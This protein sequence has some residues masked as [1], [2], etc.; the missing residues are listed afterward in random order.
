MGAALGRVAAGLEGF[1]SGSA[2]GELDAGLAF[3]AEDMTLVTRC[4]R[5]P[6]PANPGGYV[7]RPDGS[8]MRMLPVGGIPFSGPPG[9]HPQ[10]AAFSADIYCAPRWMGK[11]LYEVHD[12][13]RVLKGPPHP[14]Y[15]KKTL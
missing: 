14:T 9:S 10:F 6:D 12:K 4:V 8:F 3:A 11:E 2:N 7:R 15:R 5:V 13:G 1:G